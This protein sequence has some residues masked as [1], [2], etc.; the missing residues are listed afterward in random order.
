MKRR[1]LLWA[2]LSL[3]ALPVAARAAGDQDLRAASG[4]DWAAW[5]GP[6]PPLALPD[7]SGR[8]HTLASLRGT[9]VLLNFWASW[10]DPC[11]DEIPALSALRR[12]HYEEGLRLV[13][14]NVAE[15]PQK[16]AAFL[17]KWPV[18]GLVLHDR[19]SIALKQWHAAG[20]PANYLID[21]AGQLKYWHLGELDWNAS[22]VTAPVTALL[23]A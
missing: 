6:T 16:I 2:A 5:Q 13:A 20:L 15:S 7:L 14:V 21:R 23:R 22:Q 19:N 18:A 4:K 3:G 17:A 10:C 11:R 12:R 9:V 1:S 8:P